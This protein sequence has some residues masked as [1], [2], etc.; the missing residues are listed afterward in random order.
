MTDFDD[1]FAW[2]VNY[3]DQG[4]RATTATSTPSA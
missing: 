2:M 4:L 3:I 1:S